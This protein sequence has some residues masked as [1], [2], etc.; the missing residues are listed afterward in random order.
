M[1]SKFIFFSERSQQLFIIHGQQTVERLEPVVYL[2]FV[3]SR[4]LRFLC[5]ADRKYFKLMWYA[6]QS[7]AKASVITSCLVSCFHF[8]A[9]AELP[10]HFHISISCL[11]QRVIYTRLN[12]QTRRGHVESSL[13]NFDQDISLKLDANLA[14]TKSKRFIALL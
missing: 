14:K 2:S 4:T 10:F 7:K 12:E 3:L 13:D 5:R 11:S 1:N 6:P 8:R 9:R